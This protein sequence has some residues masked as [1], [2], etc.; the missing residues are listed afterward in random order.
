MGSRSW[1]RRRR[2]RR[3]ASGS[4]SA[5]AAACGQKDGE[6]SEAGPVTRA[7]PGEAGGRPTLPP[8]PPGLPRPGPPCPRCPRR[9]LRPA[10]GRSTPCPPPGASPGAAP[11]QPRGLRPPS[12]ELPRAGRAPAR[13]T[14]AR[15]AGR[16]HGRRRGRRK[17]AAAG[18]GPAPAAARPA[19]VPGGA[20]TLPP[21]AGRPRS[22]AGGEGRRGGS[23]GSRDCSGAAPRAP[24]NE[25][26]AAAA[27]AA[28]PAAP[29]G[30]QWCA[31][32]GP[33]GCVVPQAGTPLRSVGREKAARKSL[34]RSTNPYTTR[35]A[36]WSKSRAPFLPKQR[37]FI[38]KALSSDKLITAQTGKLSP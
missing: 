21:R 13:A 18:P 32:Q 20:D 15:G 16:M 1:T 17:E 6:D 11:P 14:G 24:S 22:R 7:G 29:R 26:A 31:G 8:P 23:G 19:P 25:G 27:R 36:L 5:L 37:F 35:G 30:P 33:L 3:G 4:P 28:R 34:E 2:P 38:V 12:R 10:A 9:H